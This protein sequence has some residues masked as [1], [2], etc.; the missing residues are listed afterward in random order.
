MSTTPRT[1][2]W[3]SNWDDTPEVLD[4]AKAM[5]EIERDLAEARSMAELA[6]NASREACGNAWRDDP[7]TWSRIAETQS[8]VAVW[9]ATGSKPDSGADVQPRE[10]WVNFYPSGSCSAWHSHAFAE[11]MATTAREGGAVHFREVIS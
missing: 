8:K 2:C 4:A 6:L 3:Q 1:N 7:A 11:D 9:L 10:I 5:R